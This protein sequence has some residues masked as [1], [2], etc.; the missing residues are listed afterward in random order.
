MIKTPTLLA[1]VAQLRGVLRAMDAWETAGGDLTSVDD[2][3]RFVASL[4]ND[5][6]DELDGLALTRLAR[7]VRAA[8]AET[9]TTAGVPRGAPG[10]AG[11][12]RQGATG[13]AA[14]PHVVTGQVS[15]HLGLPRPPSRDVRPWWHPADAM[16]TRTAGRPPVGSQP[17]GCQ[18]FA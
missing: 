5:T 2:R 16:K 7:L 10:P 11:L 6:A 1:D 13:R 3:R 4:D 17:A 14:V 18:R 15:P 12:P 8:K 9:H